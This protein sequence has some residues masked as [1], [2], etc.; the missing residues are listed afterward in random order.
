MKSDITGIYCLSLRNEAA[1][2]SYVKEYTIDVADTWER[3]E[4][5]LFFDP[6]GNWN[7]AGG[8]GL[9]INWVLASG[10]DFQAPSDGNWH[11]DNF[12]ATVNQINFNNVIDSTFEMSLPQ[13]DLGLTDPAPRRVFN[14]ESIDKDVVYIRRFIQIHTD[15]E[16]ESQKDGP[17]APFKWHMI[18]PVPMQET[19]V[20][21]SSNETFVNANSLAFTNVSGDGVTVGIAS[22]GGASGVNI[23]VK[24]DLK[25]DS[26]FLI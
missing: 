14:K 10:A 11:S 13:L 8:L 5:P 19:P 2:R 23:S 9:A 18:L 7:I 15:I 1:D 25:F 12:N 20:I 26:R 6:T 21:T 16:Y 3:K 17:S 4:I 22:T 24:L